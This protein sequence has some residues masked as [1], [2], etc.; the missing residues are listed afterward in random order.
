[1]RSQYRGAGSMKRTHVSVGINVI[2]PRRA[3]FPHKVKDEQL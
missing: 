2:K 3:L 1:M